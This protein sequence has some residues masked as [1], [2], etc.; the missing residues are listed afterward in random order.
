M[1]PVIP[2][3]HPFRGGVGDALSAVC[4][5]HLVALALH[6]R[7]K[8]VFGGGVPHA[9]VDGIHQPELPALTLGSGAVLPCAHPLLLHLLFRRRQDVQAVSGA[10][11]VT[12]LPVGLEV[13]GTLVEFFCRP[14]S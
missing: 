14:G 9:L 5:A 1:E 10:D 7:N 6:E 2:A 8:F 13:C 11:L 4:P 12:G 3:F